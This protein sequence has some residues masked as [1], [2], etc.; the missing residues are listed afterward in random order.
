[1]LRA[2]MLMNFIFL[3]TYFPF[4]NADLPYGGRVVTV[5]LQY[6]GYKKKSQYAL[7]LRTTDA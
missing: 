5:T 6:N 3:K 2:N 7:Q 4:D 1:M